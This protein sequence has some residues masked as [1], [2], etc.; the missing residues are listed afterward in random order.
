MKAA[1]IGTWH[2]HTDGYAKDFCADPR[3]QLTAV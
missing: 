1:M 3:C 2:V